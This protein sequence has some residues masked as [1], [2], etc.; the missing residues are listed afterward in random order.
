MTPTDERPI[1]RREIAG[2]LQKLGLPTGG[3]FLIHSSFRH[4]GNLAEGPRTLIDALHDTC[5]DH[6]TIAVPTFTAG[7][8]TT[9]PDYRRRT[10]HMNPRQLLDEESKIAGFERSSS[11]S[12]NV[13]IVSEYIRKHPGSFRSNHPQTSFC[14][15]GPH[16]EE[17]MATHELEC[18]LGENS[19]LKWLYDNDA[20][21]IL[22]GV[23]FG[24]CTCFHLAEY[25][26]M[27]PVESRQYRTFVMKNGRREPS[28]FYAPNTDDRDFSTIGAAMARESL[29]TWDRSV[30]RACTGSPCV[31]PSTT[32]STG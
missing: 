15:I 2:D 24:V 26:L 27:R 3:T 20:V 31:Q 5:G 10:A 16:A 32:P 12:Q 23:G 21:V 30:T 7:N 4:V 29:C 18:H 28:E 17:M 22:I 1:K 25:R 14:A 11:P 8:S 9:T 19:P 13:G 6:S